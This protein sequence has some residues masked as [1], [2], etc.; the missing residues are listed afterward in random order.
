[1][2][3]YAARGNAAKKEQERSRRGAGAGHRAACLSPGQ[4]LLGSYLCHCVCKL[5]QPTIV[6]VCCAIKRAGKCCHFALPFCHF[7]IISF[8][9]PSPSPSPDDGRLPQI[10]NKHINMQHEIGLMSINRQR[11]RERMREMRGRQEKRRET[12]T[13]PG[14]DRL[15]EP[16]VIHQWEQKKKSEQ[17]WKL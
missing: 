4:V 15:I 3:I 14:S 1:M 16:T 6:N 8:A 12:A 13:W 9:F 2:A 7:Y 17:I 11:E 5:R 10:V